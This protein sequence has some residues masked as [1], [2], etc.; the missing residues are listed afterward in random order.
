MPGAGEA[1]T[2]ELTVVERG[3]FSPGT[4][5]RCGGPRD[6]GKQR[7]CRECHNANMRRVRTP[8]RR[9]PKEEQARAKMRAHTHMLVRRGAL[10]RKPCLKCGIAKVEAHHPIPGCPYLVVWLCARH[11]R[12]VHSIGWPFRAFTLDEIT[13]ACAK[14]PRQLHSP[15]RRAA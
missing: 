12:E 14:G 2:E 3:R 5:S 11:H 9:L 15:Q 7:Y 13:V 4:C 1:L 8:Y 6:R 10:K